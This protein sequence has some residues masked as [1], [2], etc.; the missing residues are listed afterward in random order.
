MSPFA[1]V[2][3]PVGF[4]LLSELDGALAKVRWTRGPARVPKGSVLRAAARWIDEYFEGKPGPIAFPVAAAG[5]PFQ[6]RVWDAIA[7]IPSG[8]T[9]S[10]GDLARDLATSA[11]AVGGACGANPLPLVVP[12]HRVVA[13]DGTLGGFSGGAGTATKAS[14]LRRERWFAE[15][16]PAEREAPVLDV[17]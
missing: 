6:R 13:A 5:S 7:A 2:D 4:L 10:Y 16:D 11:R 17:H 3:S 14:L 12:C 15:P 8:Q 1:V 9:R